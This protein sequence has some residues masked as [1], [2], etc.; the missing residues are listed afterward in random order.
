M[1]TPGRWASIKWSLPLPDKRAARAEYPFRA[2]FCGGPAREEGRRTAGEAGIRARLYESFIK[3]RKAFIL[4]SKKD[5]IMTVKRSL[6]HVRTAQPGTA[7]DATCR[8]TLRVCGTIAIQ[9][10][11]HHFQTAWFARREADGPMD[12]FAER[13]GKSGSERGGPERV[14]ARRH[15]F[16]RGAEKWLPEL[17]AVFGARR[18]GRP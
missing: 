18:G 3:I 9:T 1:R 6:Y 16:E 12:G 8:E 14:A 11:I 4:Y 7:G 15:G 5:D 10:A 2:P 13:P 17:H